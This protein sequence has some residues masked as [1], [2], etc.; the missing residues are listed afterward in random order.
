MLSDR[1]ARTAARVPGAARDVPASES[2]KEVVNRA[3]RVLLR[4]RE[5]RP[6]LRDS[7]RGF[8]HLPAAWNCEHRHQGV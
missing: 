5:L 4:P 3:L 7:P 1:D 8:A 6:G 2:G